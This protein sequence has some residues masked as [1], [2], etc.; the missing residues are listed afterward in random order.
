MDTLGRGSQLRTMCGPY[1]CHRYAGTRSVNHGALHDWKSVVL[2]KVSYSTK[3]GSCC[4][5]PG[6]VV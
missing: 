4:S 5:T 3:A 1:H 6:M 2:D